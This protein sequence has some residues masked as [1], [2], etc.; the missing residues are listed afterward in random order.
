M[1]SLPLLG[2]AAAEEAQHYARG[3]PIIVLGG[4]GA[5]G[6][7]V[8][9]DVDDADFPVALDADIDAASCFVGNA[10]CGSGVPASAADLGIQARSADQNFAEGSEVPTAY[11][12]IE[13]AAAKMISV[14]SV[15]DA[16]DGDEVVAGIAD[17]LEP[18]LQVVAEGAHSAIKVGRG[19]GAGEAGKGVA[20]IEFHQEVLVCA[21]DGPL[22]G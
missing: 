9:V 19:S 13:E 17:D 6:G 18:R 2:G 10:V 3:G 16:A 20:G 1:G 22:P 4:V 11:P 21:G 5:E 14:Q 8:V 15:L 12:V 7:A